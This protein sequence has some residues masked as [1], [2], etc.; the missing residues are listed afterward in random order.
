MKWFQWIKSA[1]RGLDAV[2]RASGPGA[3]EGF[4]DRE[5]F[6]R[7]LQ[8]HRALCNRAGGQFILMV[9]DVSSAGTA[10]A[11]RKALD[12]LAGVI[13]RRVRVSDVAGVYG[14]ESRRLGVILPDMDLEGAAR[15]LKAVEEL[16]R[17]S[18]NGSWTPEFRLL[19]EMFS[20]PEPLA[21]LAVAEK[22]VAVKATAKTH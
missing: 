21:T 12:K 14:V 2:D 6:A 20:Y 5:A 4:L 9:F 18:M 16:M 8:R 19:C 10:Q 15:F 17:G 7:D 22:E 1:G 13:V 3:A 11:H